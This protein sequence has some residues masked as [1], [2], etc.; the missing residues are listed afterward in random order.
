[1]SNILTPRYRFISFLGKGGFGSTYLM[2]DIIV[3]KKCI[4][5]L[6]QRDVFS[7]N[8]ITIMKRI[9]N[10]GCH[11]NLICLRDYFIYKNWVAVISDYIEGNTLHKSVSDN[12]SFFIYNE[13]L[14]VFKKMIDSINYLHNIFY[15]LLYFYLYYYL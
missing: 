7:E 10:N 8:E 4:I 9:H 2:E 14:W 6:I 12:K 1:M 13:F 11:P 5:K 15:L 3:N